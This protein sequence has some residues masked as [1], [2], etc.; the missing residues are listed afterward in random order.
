MAKVKIPFSKEREERLWVSLNYMCLLSELLKIEYY[1]HFDYAFRKP[2]T[3][4]WMNRIQSDAKQIQKSLDV[5]LQSE[6]IAE[7]RAV[8]L[9]NVMKFFSERPTEEINEF[10]SKIKEEFKP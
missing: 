10:M 8:A 7:D 6:D 2:N 1:H 4:N 5:E 3:K 9:H